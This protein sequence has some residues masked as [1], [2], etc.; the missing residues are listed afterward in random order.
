[1]CAP[2]LNHPYLASSGTVIGSATPTS[3]VRK[4]AWAAH[5]TPERC[6]V[7]RRLGLG[8]RRSPPQP[9]GARAQAAK[10][11]RAVNLGCFTP[12]EFSAIRAHRPLNTA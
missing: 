12:R 8:S 10:L 1:M 5:T 4:K 2:S 9:P 6:L 7:P 3:G 11:G